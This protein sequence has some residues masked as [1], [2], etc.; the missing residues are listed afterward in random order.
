MK[1]ESFEEKLEH[2]KEV[3]EKLNSPE[4]S[5]NESMNLYKEGLKS[6]QEASA[7][8]ENAKLVYEEVNVE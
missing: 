8:L 2:A 3:L 7:L 1:E 4:I 6:L 5:L